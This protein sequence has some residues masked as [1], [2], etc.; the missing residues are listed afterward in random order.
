[1][2]E[3]E[4]LSFADVK[5]VIGQHLSTALGVRDFSITFAK[6]EGNFW[7][8]N[9]EYNEPNLI[10]TW[11]QSALLKIDASSGDIVEFEKG[12]AYSS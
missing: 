9:V 8:V 12:K 10:I 4:K 6:L 1:M 3:K 5:N 11:H 2:A 7:R